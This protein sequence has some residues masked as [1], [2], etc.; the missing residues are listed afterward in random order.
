MTSTNNE[1]L[2]RQL[3]YD[4]QT[5]YQGKV[6]FVNRVSTALE[7]QRAIPKEEII[8]WLNKQEI[9][10]KT[11]STHA[12][13]YFKIV[14]DGPG[15]YQMDLMFFPEL[16]NANKGYIGLINFI[17][18][19]TRKAYSYPIKSRNQQSINEAFDRFNEQT[20]QDNNPVYTITCDAEASLI[21]G[22][23]RYPEITLHIAK[24][25]H[26]TSTGLIERFNQTIRKLIMKYLVANNTSTYINVLPALIDNYNSSVH[27]VTLKPPNDITPTDAKEIRDKLR[28]HNNKVR[29]MRYN[30]FEVG[31][32]V[33]YTSPKQLFEKGSTNYKNM[34]TITQ[35]QGN[36]FTLHDIP[37][38]KFR[39]WEIKKVIEPVEQSP[40]PATFDRTVSSETT[41][42]NTNKQHNFYKR[43]RRE[44][45]E[46]NPMG[47]FIIK[48]RHQPT[49][50]KRV[51]KIP[52][53]F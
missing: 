34:S 10:Q 12:P 8:N 1:D 6:R 16:R 38:R 24:S 25:A 28:K 46:V 4:P 44:N 21:A 27:S 40:L 52:K 2:L 45:L 49:N 15:S 39:H 18:V 11:T 37:N 30:Q 14:A 32:K 51:R 33:W 23:R 19:T 36:T 20:I 47:E 26:K 3:Y 13:E 29:R 7:R 42:E 50:E 48:P 5:G 17:E 35:K 43:Q 41:I 31:D 22:V 9:Y 53:R